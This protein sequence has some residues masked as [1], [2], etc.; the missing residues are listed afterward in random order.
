[1]P[2]VPPEGLLRKFDL[3]GAFLEHA[4]AGTEATAAES[5]A[6]AD[7]EL[8][9]S[10]HDVLARGK[11]RGEL[12]VVCSRCAGPARLSLAETFNVM[13]V[14]RGKVDVELAD[15]EEPS[16]DPDLV[17]YDGDTIDLGELMREELLLAFPL[18]PLCQEACRGLCPR[19]GADLNQGPCGC[20]DEPRD[21]RFAPLKNLKV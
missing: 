19:C 13:Y 9:R 3:T 5:S 16:D 6:H 20:P 1:V 14:P 15:T 10:G 12:T 4:L 7:V 8:T 18:A 21:D 2:E 17:A 11:L